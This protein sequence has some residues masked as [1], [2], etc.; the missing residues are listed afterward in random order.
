LIEKFYRFNLAKIDLTQSEKDQSKS[1]RNV[2]L[3]P[4][5]VLDIQEHVFCGKP[6]MYVFLKNQHHRVS[7]TAKIKIYTNR[8]TISK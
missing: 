7:I 3:E 4:I 8:G 5:A 1:T 6:Q 2:K